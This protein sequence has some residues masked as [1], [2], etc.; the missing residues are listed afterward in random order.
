MQE[1]FAL[2]CCLLE[3]FSQIYLK[4]EDGGEGFYEVKS[5]TIA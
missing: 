4:L 1:F 2:I 5:D 3:K